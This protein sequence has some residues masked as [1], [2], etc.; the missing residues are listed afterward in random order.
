[1]ITAGRIRWGME[2]RTPI[3]YTDQGAAGSVLHALWRNGRVY[4][5]CLTAPKDV[6]PR[7]L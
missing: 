2:A 4:G 1:M 5:V 6:P 7:R 3:L